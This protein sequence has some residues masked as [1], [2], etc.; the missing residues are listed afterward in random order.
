MP[1]VSEIESAIQRLEGGAYQK[2]MDS[3]LCKRYGLQD[4]FIW[5]SDRVL[6]RTV[7]GTPDTYAE[8]PNGKYVYVMYGTHIDA[9]RKLS[10]DLSKC[11]AE[12]TK[13]G[14]E[15]KVEKI[16]C[17]HTATHMSNVT[18][19]KLNALYDNLEIL[20][21]TETAHDLLYKYPEIA[22]TRVR[23]R[24]LDRAESR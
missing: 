22:G 9:D 3:Y 7:K 1:N 11:M 13:I 21:I 16:I 23:N 2:L 5:F 10:D 19:E 20:G 14:F 12:I 6:A 17:C 18:Y 4:K 8:L 15:N 24:T